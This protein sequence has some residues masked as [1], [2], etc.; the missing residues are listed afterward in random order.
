[1]R[2]LSILLCII[3]IVGCQSTPEPVG[4]KVNEE[5]L[6]R[7]A[8]DAGNYEGAA[9]YYSQWLAKYPESWDIF[10]ERG[11]AYN[12]LQK[13]DLALKDFEL[14]SERN[15]ADLRPQIYR[16]GVLI[17]LKKYPPARTI[18]AGLVADA[19]LAQLGAYEQFLAFFL[20]SQLKN[21]GGDYENALTS[22]EEALKQCEL[23]PDVFQMR[24]AAS[25]QRLALRERAIAYHYLG[26]Y[27]Q[28]ATDIEQYIV[29]TEQA[30]GKA[31]PK[32]YQ[33]LA[34]ALYMSDD[35]EKCRKVLPRLSLQERRELAQ[36]FPADAEFFVPPE[37][38][39][40][41]AQK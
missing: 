8:F 26:N 41:P 3:A 19:R 2:N 30:E 31:D 12:R 5:E 4:P 27:R 24:G 22:V 10:F 25:I 34:L 37:P 18:V 1:M 11:R 16:A 9:D 36:I 6:G 14:A 28:A 20:D 21:L 13:Y 40:K 7:Q 32:D 17:S 38:L 39:A 35:Y 15:P 29:M 23:H 33:S